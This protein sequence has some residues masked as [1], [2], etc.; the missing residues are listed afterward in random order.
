MANDGVSLTC[1]PREVHA[2]LGQNGAGKTTLMKVLAGH[3][4]PDSGMIRLRGAMVRFGNPQESMRAGIGVV[5]QHFSLV[6]ELSVAE[7][8]FLN[9]PQ[10]G[11][12]FRPH[13]LYPQIYAAAKRA[14]VEVDPSARIGRLSEAEKQKVEILKVI[15]HGANILILDEPTSMLAPQE[16]DTL[17]DHVRQFVGSGGIVLLV[18]HKVE[19]VLAVATHVTV[20]RAGQVVAHGPAGEFEADRLILLMAGRDGDAAALGQGVRESSPDRTSREMILHARDLGMPARSGRCGLE[21]VNISLHAHEILGVAGLAGNGQD[22]LIDAIL[23]W[24]RHRPSLQVRSCRGT[25]PRIGIVPGNRTLHGLASS[26][27]VEENLLMRRYA[28]AP[29]QRF[30]FLS[31]ANRRRFSDEEISR[32]SIQPDKRS[33]SLGTLSGGNRQKVLLAREL[34]F[35]PDLLVAVYPTAGLDLS[36]TQFTFKAIREAA[37]KGC[38]VLVVSEDLDELLALCDRIAVLHQGRIVGTFPAD[39]SQYKRIGLAMNG[40]AEP[41]SMHSGEGEPTE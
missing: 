8:I 4:A 25:A 36:A 35:D 1:R 17:F 41:T 3:F 7:N 24:T 28:I 11:P 34:D 16:A 20:L 15:L 38:A 40:M 39:H 27:S 30:G 21:G 13:V 32:F 14:G 2:V 26:L 29:F 22:D 5:H 23:A 33:A 9:E 19:H 37:Q 12:R 10:F 6:D 31:P 18:T